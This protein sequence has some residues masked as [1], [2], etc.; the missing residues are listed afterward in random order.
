MF[1]GI[2]DSKLNEDSK[3]IPKSP[4]A[5]SKVF[6]HQMTK[7]YRESYDVFG[8]NGILFNHES[9]YRGETFVTRKIT[10]AIGRIHY[11]IQKN[12]HLETWTHL[13]TGVLQET[14]SKVCG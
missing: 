13:G 1:G 8:V 12:S 2:D 7:I 5:A 6:A 11:G 9:P 4:Y 10:R 14:T 3:F